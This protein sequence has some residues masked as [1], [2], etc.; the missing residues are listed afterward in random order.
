MWRQLSEASMPVD[1]PTYHQSFCNSWEDESAC[2]ITSRACWC[3]FFCYP[4]RAAPGWPRVPHLI[5]RSPPSLGPRHT[6]A[7]TGTG[8]SGLLKV[9]RKQLRLFFFIL[10]HPSV[11]HYSNLVTL[12]MF[13]IVACTCW[14]SISRSKHSF[15]VKEETSVQAI[16]SYWK[17]QMHQHQYHMCLYAN[18]NKH[19]TVGMFNHKTP[20]VKIKGNT[21]P[22]SVSLSC[23]VLHTNKNISFTL[24]L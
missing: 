19:W 14:D 8:F 3:L 10:V 21:L 4:S 15:N 13:T 22:Q 11:C 9:D 6:L 23:T 18:T 12:H 17:T 16:H 20:A 2:W 1:Y 5:I 7:G 24:T